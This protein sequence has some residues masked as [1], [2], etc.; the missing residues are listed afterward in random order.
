MKLI[1]G[2][3][4]PG[5]KFQDTRH[6]V[7]FMVIDELEKMKDKISNDVILFKPQTFM[8]RSGEAILQKKNYYKIEPQ[9]IWVISDDINLRLGEIRV[10]M[11]G[12]SGGHKGLESIIQNLK[13]EKFPRFRIGIG[14]NE[15][16]PSEEYV[17]QKFST[18]ERKVIADA[19]TGCAK[20]IIKSIKN[21]I[22][23]ET[24]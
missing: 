3:G 20:I 19:I 16:V 2:L 5:K 18:K 10:R 23:E 11:Q 8:N 14:E 13:T 12:S 24:I 17:L 4:N 7:G 21:G 1:V 9:N 22:K 6:N 15:N